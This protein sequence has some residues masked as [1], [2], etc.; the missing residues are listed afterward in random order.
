MKDDYQNFKLFIRGITLKDITAIIVL[1]ALAVI[2]ERY[3]LTYGGH[4]FL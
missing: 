4:I 3:D 2:L 1:T